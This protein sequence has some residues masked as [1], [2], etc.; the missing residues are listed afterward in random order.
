[1]DGRGIVAALA[2][3]ASAVQMGTAFLTSDECGASAIYKQAVLDAADDVTALTRAFSGRW[4][5][6]IRN[7]FMELSESSEAL[8]YPWQ[9]SLTGPMRAAAARK[10]D[11]NYVSLFAGQGAALARR[12][13]AAALMAALEREMQEAIKDVSSLR[14]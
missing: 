12:M 13:P 7:R 8:S 5:R 1:M 11:R 4:A 6:G 14:V 3:G 9:N 2:L 10:G